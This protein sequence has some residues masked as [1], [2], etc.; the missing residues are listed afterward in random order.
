MNPLIRNNLNFILATE[1][2]V[3][4]KNLR[5]KYMTDKRRDT[6]GQ[7]SAE[8]DKDAIAI[9]NALSYIDTAI[10]RRQAAMCLA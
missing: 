5:L 7:A 9:K 4:F 1:C 2:N 6:S 8:I 3:M 10:I